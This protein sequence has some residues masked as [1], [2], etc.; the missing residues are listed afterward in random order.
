VRELVGGLPEDQRAVLLL[1]LVG[2]LSAEEV[3]STLGKS[4]G[5]VR[6]LQH[7]AIATLR[8]QLGVR[9]EEGVTR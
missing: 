5:A 3:A 4:N 8:R 6:A 1:R 9:T 7:R 2:D